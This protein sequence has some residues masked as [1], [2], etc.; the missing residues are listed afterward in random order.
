MFMINLVE[1]MCFQAKLLCI[2]NWLQARFHVGQGQLPVGASSHEIVCSWRLR[3]VFMTAFQSRNS[4]FM[5]VLPDFMVLLGCHEIFLCGVALSWNISMTVLHSHEIFS[6]ELTTVTNYLM[7]PDD[8]HNFVVLAV[9]NSPHEI[10][11]WQS[12]F[13]KI[14]FSW[15]F[16]REGT[17][18][19]VSRL[20]LFSWSFWC[21]RDVIWTFTKFPVS[22]S[23]VH[24]RT[25]KF[26]L[27]ILKLCR[28]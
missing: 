17:F 26:T 22:G 8:S 10:C 7:K 9:V 25:I 18:M 16:V 11:S 2:E 15:R 6:R 1:W 27:S 21:F 28:I 3:N 20:E 13:T 5:T 19:T 4:V 14:L 23:F 24:P 12:T